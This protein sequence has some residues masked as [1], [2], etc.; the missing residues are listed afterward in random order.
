MGHKP[1]GIPREVSVHRNPESIASDDEKWVFK[2]RPVN[3]GFIE[4]SKKLS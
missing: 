2:L 1:L 4:N 3:C